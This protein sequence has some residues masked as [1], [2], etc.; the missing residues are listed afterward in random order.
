MEKSI[1]VLTAVLATLSFLLASLK[2]RIKSYKK[3]H[4]PI[5]TPPGYLRD[6]PTI[7]KEEAAKRAFESKRPRIVQALKIVD[8]LEWAALLATAVSAWFSVQ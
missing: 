5:L 4:A 6:Q 7:D 3:K 2:A 1:Q 8:A